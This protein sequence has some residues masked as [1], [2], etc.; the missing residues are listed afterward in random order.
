MNKTKLL[1][2]NE[3]KKGKPWFK[4]Y[5]VATHTNN[6]AINFR[7]VSDFTGHLLDPV[8]ESLEASPVADIVN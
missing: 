2:T 4:I 7:L 8:I 1:E 5:L 6:N 3:K